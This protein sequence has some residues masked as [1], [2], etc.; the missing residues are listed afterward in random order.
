MRSTAYS[1]QRIDYIYI[2]FWFED[3]KERENSEDLGVYGRITLEFIL[4]K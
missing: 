2:I 4:G 3:L 1:T